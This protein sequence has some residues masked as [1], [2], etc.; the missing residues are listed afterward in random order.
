MIDC[1]GEDERGGAW[2]N[3]LGIMGPATFPVL[4]ST[5]QGPLAWT[6]SQTLSA[7]A[8]SLAWAET[9]MSGSLGSWLP[10]PLQG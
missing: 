3:D 9:R 5:F 6:P 2:T 7:G 8:G 10:S 4:P 1:K